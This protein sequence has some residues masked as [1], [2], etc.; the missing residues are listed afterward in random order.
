MIRRVASLALS[1]LLAYALGYSHGTWR[2][3]ADIDERI[4]QAIE[5]PWKTRWLKV[6]ERAEQEANRADSLMVELQ[7]VRLEARP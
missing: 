3:H 6:Y 5:E 7:N 1:L 2:A 4:V